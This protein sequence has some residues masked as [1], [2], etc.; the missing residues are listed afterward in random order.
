VR[1][2]TEQAFP[3]WQG[4]GTVLLGWA[5]AVGGRVDEGI[6]QIKQG[7]AL[8][9]S[10]GVRV[11]IP[12]CLAGLAEAC[13]KGGQIEEGLSAIND[14]LVL[15]EQTG[16]RWWETEIYRLKGHLLLA[17]SPDHQVE[18]EKCF[19]QAIELARGKEARSL[20][21]KATMSLGELWRDQGKLDAA[22]DSLAEIY[23]WFTEGF[24][25]PYLKKA[26]ALLEELGG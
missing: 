12:G 2:S 7:L 3:F 17:Q 22:R 23:G 26:K 9:E 24:D 8:Y 10:I 19:Q 13:W 18:A 16:E 20:E 11:F 15:V 6:A 25:T 21:L 1:L 5:L 4:G 14:A